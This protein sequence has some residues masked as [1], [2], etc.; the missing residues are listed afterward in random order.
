MAIAYI[1]S[2]LNELM[3]ITT[4]LTNK[5]QKNP[6][7]LPLWFSRLAPIVILPHSERS[8]TMVEHFESGEFQESHNEVGYYWVLTRL[9]QLDTCFYWASEINT[10]RCLQATY[11]H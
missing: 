10:I 4:Y 6:S 3:I 5:K 9:A 2:G 1:E 8:L 11:P 7:K